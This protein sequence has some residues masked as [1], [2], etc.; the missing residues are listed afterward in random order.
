MFSS[1]FAAMQPRSQQSAGTYHQVGVET[2]VDGA[3]PHQLIALLFD[4]LFTALSRARHAF[5]SNDK[6]ARAKAISH[7]TRIVNEGLMSGLDLQTGGKLA[8]DLNALYAYVC[9]RLTQA[10]ANHDAAALAECVAL[11]QPVREAW[12]AI[13]P[14]AAAPAASPGS[15]S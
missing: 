2:A 9:L 12:G 10:N 7:A 5:D 1:P 6:L 13:G 15:Y 14:A 11:L 3:S 8:A 4:G